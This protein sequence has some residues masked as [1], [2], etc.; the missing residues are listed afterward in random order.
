MILRSPIVMASRPATSIAFS[1]LC[2]RARPSLTAWTPRS[3]W[4]N[5]APLHSLAAPTRPPRRFQ[6]HFPLMDRLSGVLSYVTD[7][8]NKSLGFGATI[9]HPTTHFSNLSTE[10]KSCWKCGSSLPSTAVV[11][12]QNSCDAVQQLAYETNFF[13][14]LNDGNVTFDVNPRQI[15]HVFLRLQ[16]D[17]HPDNFA[18]K[19]ER[20]LRLSE[21]QSSFINKAY[22]T[23]K[24]PLPRALYLLS[25]R[26]IPVS[27]SDTLDDTELLM[28]I[29]ELREE[30]EEAETQEEVDDIRSRN[31]VVT[32]KLLLQL[33]EA[34]RADPADYAVLKRLVIELQYR[35]NVRDACVQWNEGEERKM[36]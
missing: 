17:V 19:S 7:H 29:L 21:V 16:Q 22:Q 9:L 25:L 31:D 30:L 3:S 10:S 15:R 26:D 20:E 6:R 32:D 24:D 23:L 5:H 1:S 35:V 14:V 11:C 13:D 28:E 33:S 18:A 4:R 27:E 36:R 34:F 12:T 2:P 8:Y